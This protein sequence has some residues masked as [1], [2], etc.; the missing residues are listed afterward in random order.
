[1]ASAA[2]SL[3]YLRDLKKSYSSYKQ[4][5]IKSVVKFIL[6]NNVSRAHDGAGVSVNERSHLACPGG[7]DRSL[8]VQPVTS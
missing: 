5:R 6:S 4:I 8:L 7:V 2:F 1:M 3:E